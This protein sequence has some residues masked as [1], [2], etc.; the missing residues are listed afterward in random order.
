MGCVSASIYRIFKC[1]AKSIP[2]GIIYFLSLK[3]NEVNRILYLQV[4]SLQERVTLF[5]LPK[6]ASYS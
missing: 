6:Y 3:K 4:G 5:S 2:W 1:P